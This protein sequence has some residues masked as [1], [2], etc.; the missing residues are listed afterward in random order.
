MQY[1]YDP[2]NR[3]LVWKVAVSIWS[4]PIFLLKSCTIFTTPFSIQ[5]SS[6]P[7][8]FKVLIAHKS[9]SSS[10][11]SFHPEKNWISFYL[12]ANL[13]KYCEF[14][15]LCL[16]SI[17]VATTINGRFPTAFTSQPLFLVFAD[18]NENI[19]FDCFKER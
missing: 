4:Q 10:R 6:F 9:I 14:A 2:F 3:K 1:K 15:L 12:V 19:S 5:G 13:G 11:F 7:T 16:L 18:K 17:F 8:L